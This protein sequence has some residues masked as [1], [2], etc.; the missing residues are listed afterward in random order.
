MS[1]FL[2]SALSTFSSLTFVALIVVAQALVP[3]DTLATEPVAHS[4]ELGEPVDARRFTATAEKVEFAET[5]AEE[6]GLGSSGPIEAHG[7]WVVATVEI[8]AATAPLNSVD[9]EL[10]MGD[11]YVYSASTWVSNGLNGGGSTPAP[12]I[13]LT[14][15]LVFEVPEKRVDDPAL[16]VSARE[17]VDDRLSARADI[18]LGLDGARLD[19]RLADP[20]ERIAVPAPAQ[21]S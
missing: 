12:G 14:G 9:A 11:G 19:E 4:G 7:V 16:H 3:D 15:M 2:R 6:G 13:P 18:H 10:V 17:S 20:Q 21:T 8:T 5:V 1:P